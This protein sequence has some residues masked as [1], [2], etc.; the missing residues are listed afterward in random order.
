MIQALI[1]LV[2]TKG[3]HATREQGTCILEATAWTAGEPH[4]D[5]P[6]CV[7]DSIGTFAR[8]LN[9]ACWPSDQERTKSLRPVIPLLIGTNDHMDE[10]RMAF[11]FTD[12]AIREFTPIALES[13]VS[14]MNVDHAIT[15]QGRAQTLRELSPIV[16]RATA[17]AAVNVV[18]EAVREVQDGHKATEDAYYTTH[19]VLNAAEDIYTTVNAVSKAA[20]DTPAAINSISVISAVNAA[21][22]TIKTAS[23]N[24]DVCDIVCDIVHSTIYSIAYTA[25]AVNVANV[26]LSLSV[27]Q[28]A[29][30][31]LCYVCKECRLPEA[32]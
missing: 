7:D 30:A 24:V 12:A 16:D 21:Y 31:L 20:D 6:K 1:S 13:M 25:K 18:L 15:L 29:T 26:N 3:S 11:I 14:F 8:K 23:S 22:E 9:D 10:E 28:S 27:L 17:T 32:K 19:A 4:S 2:L 5:D